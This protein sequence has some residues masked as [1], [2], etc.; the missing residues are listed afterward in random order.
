MQ[1]VTLQTGAIVPLEGEV[2]CADCGEVE[3]SFMMV[4][5]ECYCDDCYT[6]AR[7]NQIVHKGLDAIIESLVEIIPQSEWNQLAWRISVGFGG[8]PCPKGINWYCELVD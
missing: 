3:S 5:N 8:E 7:A 1:T 2:S 6:V 4:E